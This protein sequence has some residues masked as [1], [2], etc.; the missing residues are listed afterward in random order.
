MTD[1]LESLH[2]TYWRL[3]DSPTCASATRAEALLRN[4]AELVSTGSVESVEWFVRA[5]AYQPYKLF[6]ARTLGRMD[7]SPDELL[8]LLIHAAAAER[9]METSN[10]FLAAMVRLY[11]VQTVSRRA[12]EIARVKGKRRI[13]DF[14]GVSVR[15]RNLGAN[16]SSKPTPLRGPA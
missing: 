3:L 14:V 4:A 2:K 13:G 15:A 1:Q 7:V 8:D 9:N 6:A 10:L 16:D 11:G 12:F 5:L